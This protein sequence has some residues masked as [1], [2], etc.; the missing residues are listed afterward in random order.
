[1]TDMPL[2]PKEITVV[3]DQNELDRLDA[4]VGEVCR[5][6]FIREAVTKLLDHRE[7]LNRV[8]YEDR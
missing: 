2:T 8:Y 3:I 1:M 7:H 5:G 6:S 4:L